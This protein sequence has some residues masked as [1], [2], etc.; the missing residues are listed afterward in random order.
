MAETSFSCDVSQGFNFKKDAQ[1]IVGHISKLKI[2]EKDMDVDLAM[3]NPEDL[4]GDKI[5]VV[6]VVSDIYWNGGFAEP[7]QFSCQV[8]NANKKT[9]AIL[10][11]S[12]MSNTTV[13]FAFEVYDYDPEEKKYFKAFHTDGAAIKGLVQKSGGSLSIAISTDQSMEVMSPNNFTLSLG[14]MPEDTE[15]ET[16]LAFS[17]SDKLVKRWGVTVAA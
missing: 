14:V 3:T 6:G 2:G 1:D 10:T 9:L 5:K 13:E 11:N 15:Q 17:V 7:I 16:H 8:S 12:E 4:A